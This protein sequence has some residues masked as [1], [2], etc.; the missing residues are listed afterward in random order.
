VPALQLAEALQVE[1]V[2]VRV[3]GAPRLTWDT[4]HRHVD[5][6][7]VSAP[8]TTVTVTYDQSSKEIRLN[9]KCFAFLLSAYNCSIVSLKLK[10]VV[11]SF[12]LNDTLYLNFTSLSLSLSLSLSE[13]T[14]SLGK[15]NRTYRNK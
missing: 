6:T 9:G 2:L 10:A 11:T 12:I 3:G 7:F 15:R 14:S 13:L 4:R 8:R 1:Q 5:G